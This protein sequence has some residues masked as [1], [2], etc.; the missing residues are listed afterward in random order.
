[1]ALRARIVLACTEESGV[2]PLTAVADRTRM[3]RESAR[4]SGCGSCGTG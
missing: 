2:V 4:S 1:M 3:S